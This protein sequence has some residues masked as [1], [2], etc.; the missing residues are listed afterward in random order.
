ML[1]QEHEKIPIMQGIVMVFL[2]LS[3]VS[4]FAWGPSYLLRNFPL[5][6]SSLLSSVISSLSYWIHSINICACNNLCHFKKCF[7]ND[8]SF[9]SY[10]TSVA[11]CLKD[12][13]ILK[14]QFSSSYFVLNCSLTS[15][16]ILGIFLNLSLSEYNYITQ[17]SNVCK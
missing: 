6:L 10:H 1:S 17:L 2:I 14:S 11:K 7:W 8:L 5:W 12:L 3:T 9:A 15:D 4:L 16:L 13:S